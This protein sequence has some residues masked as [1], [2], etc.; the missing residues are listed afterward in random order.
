MQVIHLDNPQ[1]AYSALVESLAIPVQFQE[2]GWKET[3]LD[4]SELSKLY[5]EKGHNDLLLLTIFN[6]FQIKKQNTLP[7]YHVFKSECF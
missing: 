7:A 1:E 6:Y 3:V 5:L 2:T 4:L